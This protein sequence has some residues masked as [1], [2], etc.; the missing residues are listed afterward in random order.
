MNDINRVRGRLPDL[1]DL[2]VLRLQRHGKIEGKMPAEFAQEFG[3][4]VI[5]DYRDIRALDRLL[6]GSMTSLNDSQAQVDQDGTFRFDA[7]VE[8]S[9]WVVVYRREPLDASKA[10]APTRQPVAH[11]SRRSSSWKNGNAS[12]RYSAVAKVS[13]RVVCPEATSDFSKIAVID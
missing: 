6:G 13:G 10:T 9:N 11:A 2:C 5:R 8:G 12:S 3:V 7:V 1:R 4:R